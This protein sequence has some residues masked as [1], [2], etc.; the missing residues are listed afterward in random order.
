MKTII[1][2][3]SLPDDGN[4]HGDIL[5]ALTSDGKLYQSSQ[6]TKPVWIEIPG[7]EEETDI[8]F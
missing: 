3:I 6:R 8:K 4:S 7:I 2:I 1:Q 5:I